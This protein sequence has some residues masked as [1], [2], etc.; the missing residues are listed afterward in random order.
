MGDGSIYVGVGGAAECRGE[1]SLMSE[2][3]VG[4][5]GRSE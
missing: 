2:W 5:S 4:V 3:S 1:Q